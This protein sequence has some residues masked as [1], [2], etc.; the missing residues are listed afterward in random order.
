MQFSERVFRA[1]VLKSAGDLLLAHAAVPSNLCKKCA[2]VPEAGVLPFFRCLQRH[3]FGSLVLLARS[4][5]LLHCLL[6]PSIEIPLENLAR[7]VLHASDAFN[8]SSIAHPGGR[9]RGCMPY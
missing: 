3:N 6:C 7:N 4:P 9:D 8:S 5:R 2:E 1:I